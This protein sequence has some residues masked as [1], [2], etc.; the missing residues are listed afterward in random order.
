[1]NSFLYLRALK[2]SDFTV[3][4]VQDGQKTFYDVQ[5]GQSMPYSSGQQI[6]RSI[7][8]TFTDSLGVQPAP[9]TFISDVKVKGNKKE[10]GEGE[11][12]SLC[13]PSYPDQLIGGYMRAE[14][15]GEN[16]TIKR[17]SPLSISA[18]RPLHPLLARTHK[19]NITYDRSDRPELHKVVVRGTDGKP[20]S[21][22][23]I[24]D[25]LKGVDKSL[26]R[27]WIPENKRAGG[28]FIYDIAIDLRRLFT[29]STNQF[30]PEISP[31]IIE[32]L[33]NEGWT[34]G[35]TVFGKCLVAPA[36]KRKKMTEA[37]ADA[38]INWQI[39][40][41]QSRTFSL[42]ETLAIVISDNANKVASAIRASLDEEG[43][44]AEPV[45]E[46]NSIDGVSTFV[47]SASTGYLSRVIV[48][49]DALEQAKAELIKRIEAYE[50]K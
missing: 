40:S 20:L 24:T 26:H 30:E 23:E 28:L 37:L 32:K 3:F 13:D 39:T 6:K 21:D 7:M 12:L 27:K 15:G 42:M 22:D 1:M 41:N 47:S 5:F 46:Q 49:H 31:A 43:K 29:V 14:S 18:M 16:R 11:P 45:V 19:E 35:Q 44:R 48:A 17:R 50:F 4:G 9:I 25:L 38:L 2:H 10:L 8:D 33:R 34:D 36:D